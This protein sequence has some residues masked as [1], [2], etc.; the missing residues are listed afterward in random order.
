MSAALPVA[1]LIALAYVFKK[2]WDNNFGGIRDAATAIAAGFR[3]ATTAGED[4]I[5]RVDAAVA[6][7][8][9]DLGL[10]DM[11]ITAGKVFYRIRTFMKGFIRGFKEIWTEIKS[12]GYLIGE[13]FAPAISGGE[14]FLDMIGLLDSAA[15]TGT[16]SWGDWGE[17][18]GAFLTV[19]LAITAAAKVGAIVVG[20]LT[21]AWQAAAIAVKLFNYAM[22]LNPIWLIVALVVGAIAYMVMN[23]DKFRDHVIAIFRGFFDFFGGIMDMIVGI[24]TGD[25]ELV[26][27]G[28][29]RAFEGLEAYIF[30]WVGVIMGYLQ[31]VF[32]AINWV[33][34]KMG[35]KDSALTEQIQGMNAPEEVKQQLLGRAATLDPEAAERLTGDLSGISATGISPK[36][37]NMM[38]DAAGAA[39]TSAPLAAT[40]ATA[41]AAQNSNVNVSTEVTAQEV[42]IVVK[43]DGDAIGK[44]VMKYNVKQQVRG[45]DSTWN[46]QS[47]SAR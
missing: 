11:A 21:K 44:G 28:F 8:L 47:L 27:S 2:A 22:M 32:D 31:P 36:G 20:V 24:F 17:R 40:S 10:W 34:K 4:G 46:A 15:K 30:G 12:Y 33:L 5:A 25:V 43:V 16:S 3:M 45:G 39:P 1:G 6:K 35:L 18:I 38:L 9:K 41:K 23:W 19:L 26:K 29:I 37:M 13:F 14:K 7:K 42:P